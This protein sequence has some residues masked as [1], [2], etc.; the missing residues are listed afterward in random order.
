MLDVTAT[1]KK[2]MLVIKQGVVK[3]KGR[4]RSAGKLRAAAGWSRGLF[5]L[6]VK[7]AIVVVVAHLL[8]C[9]HSGERFQ[10][11]AAFFSCIDKVCVL[12]ERRSYDKNEDL[13]PNTV[14]APALLKD[15]W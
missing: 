9:G 5:N 2:P 1:Y 12:G 4:H 7:N 13:S 11:E 15:E 8:S 14:L 10:V 3:E 6:I